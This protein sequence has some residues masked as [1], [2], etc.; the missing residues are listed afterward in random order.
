MQYVVFYIKIQYK[1][2]L[3]EAHSKNSVISQRKL[4]L[5]K[6]TEEK[7]SPVPGMR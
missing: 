5:P 1:H 7:T 4:S 6:Q 2:T 3:E